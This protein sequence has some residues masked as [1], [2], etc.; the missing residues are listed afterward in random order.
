MLFELAVKE[1]HAVAGLEKMAS[2]MV[3]IRPLK[4]AILTALL[5]G[6]RRM[7]ARPRGSRW[8]PLAESTIERKRREGLPPQILVATGKLRDSL[9][10]EAG[11]G[12]IREAGRDYIRFGTTVLE[13]KF[14]V[15][16]TAN[17]GQGGQRK[18]RRV[19]SKRDSSQLH[20]PPRRILALGARE[21]RE[22]K[23]AIAR[24]LIGD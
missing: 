2:R 20:T 7:W 16:G 6:E 12:S 1:R 11:D 5:E 3:D 15:K 13:A 21:K 8:A 14:Q 18:H 22:I 23:T 4:G 9:T 10:Q 17:P 19:S 24:Y